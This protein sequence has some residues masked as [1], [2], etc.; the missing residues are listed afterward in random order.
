MPFCSVWSYWSWDFLSYPEVAE[1]RRSCMLSSTTILILKRAATRSQLLKRTDNFIG[2][3]SHRPLIGLYFMYVKKSQDVLRKLQESTTGILKGNWDEWTNGEMVGKLCDDYGKRAHI[4]VEKRKTHI[5]SDRGSRER[6][7]HHYHESWA[8]KPL[9]GEKWPRF[10]LHLRRACTCT[11]GEKFNTLSHKYSN[12][13]PDH[14]SIIQIPS[15]WANHGSCN[16]AWRC[17]NA[18]FP[19]LVILSTLTLL[20]PS[21]TSGE[22]KIEWG[23]SQ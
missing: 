16:V 22:A 12:F 21:S 8:R 18:E 3:N 13:T 14:A 17:E 2:V 6:K 19:H 1:W 5:R 10:H 4:C 9:E 23:I 11:R 20:P 7:R 15:S